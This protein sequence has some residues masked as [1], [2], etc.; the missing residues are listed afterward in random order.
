MLGGTAADRH[1]VVVRE[2]LLY[3]VESALGR[4]AFELLEAR[5]APLRDGDVEA[6]V[7]Q[8]DAQGFEDPLLVVDDEDRRCGGGHYAAS[9]FRRAAGK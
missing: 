6:L 7:L 8:Q 5:L 3:I 1:H 2:R 4:R 9:S